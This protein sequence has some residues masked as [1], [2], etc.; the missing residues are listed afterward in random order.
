MALT[1]KE[2]KNVKAISKA[3]KFADSGGMYLLVQSNGAKYWR[4]DYRFA[5]RRKT[6][7]LGVY[8]ELSL[9]EA[10]SRRDAARNLLMNGA[11]PSVVKKAQKLSRVALTENTFENVARE[12]FIK[13]EPNWAVTHSSKVIRRLEIYVFPWIGTRPISEIT[14][15]EL[16]AM[17][18]RVESRG[19]LDT[20]HRVHQ[21]CGQVF[22][23]AIATGRA[24]RNPSTDLRGAIPPAIRQHYP[25]ITDPKAVGELLR[26]IYGYTGTYSTCYALRLA[27]MFALRPSELRK[28]EW[29]E[30]DLDKAEWRIP[31]NRMLKSKQP[32][33]VPLATQALVI[34]R[35]L[36]CMFGSGKYVFPSPRTST[37]PMSNNT[38]NAALHRMG[39]KGEFVGHA[40]R[41]VASTLLN[42]QGW[43]YD[44][45]E[46]QL[47]HVGKGIRAV[48]N[49]AQYLP[50]RR[51]MMQHWA[52]YLDGLA[53]GADVMQMHQKVG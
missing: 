51:R 15:P 40:F 12:W 19:I 53:K 17:L 26:A 49:Y 13:H 29:C 6:L 11:D 16:L 27:P 50:E 20:A 30:I 33:I 38:I 22:C 14:A 48:Y 3:T 18:R 35:E 5:G 24:S 34:L 41:S 25:T 37:K 32:H 47:S 21:N 9:V 10:R 1:A 2:V 44:A 36:H 52:D 23:Y 7:A 42:E 28:A 39:Y 46:K 8:P 31:A 43:N 45:I 4:L